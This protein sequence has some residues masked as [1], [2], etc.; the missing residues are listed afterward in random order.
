MNDS[1]RLPEPNN[2]SSQSSLAQRDKQTTDSDEQIQS[3]DNTQNVDLSNRAAGQSE[4]KKSQNQPQ[5]RSSLSSER[6]S[7]GRFLRNRRME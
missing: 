2:S 3:A 5:F 7:I 1:P 6:F 4:K